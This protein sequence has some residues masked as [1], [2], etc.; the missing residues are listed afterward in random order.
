MSADTAPENILSLAFQVD[1][2]LVDDQELQTEVDGTWL[3]EF[4]DSDPWTGFSD[5]Q[6][7]MPRAKHLVLKFAGECSLR[8]ALSKY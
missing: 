3:R 7:S 8:A 5:D 6:K 1:L 4:W 2:D